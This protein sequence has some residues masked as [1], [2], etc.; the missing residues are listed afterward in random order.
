M[1]FFNPE[2]TATVVGILPVTASCRPSPLG[3][4]LHK[5]PRWLCVSR[6]VQF[7]L[8]L[9]NYATSVFFRL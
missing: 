9:A 2:P 6:T 8:A 7:F 5:K 3:S 4:W 1:F